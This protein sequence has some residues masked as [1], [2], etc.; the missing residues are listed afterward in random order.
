MK[1]GPV[2]LRK[3]LRITLAFLLAALALPQT[4]FRPQGGQSAAGTALAAEAAGA[5]TGTAVLTSALKS[6]QKGASED[7][8]PAHPQGNLGTFYQ[9]YLSGVPALQ[10]TAAG[11]IGPNLDMLTD[12][13]ST[14]E[15]KLS[16]LLGTIG[17]SPPAYTISD[18]AGGFYGIRVRDY[19][20]KD[21]FNAWSAPLP[22]AAAWSEL[23]PDIPAL[24]PPDKNDMGD[25]DAED[26]LLNLDQ[27]L[28]YSAALITPKSGKGLL[29][30]AFHDVLA[31]LW[32]SKSDTGA[33]FST[34]FSSSVPI[35]AE[36]AMY[37]TGDLRGASAMRPSPSAN[38][39]YF[40]EGYVVRDPWQD[41]DT[42]I[43]LQNRGDSSAHATVTFFGN[44]GVPV[45][46]E[47][48]VPPKSRRT[49]NAFEH[50]YGEVST[51]VESDAPLSAERSLYLQ[52][53]LYGST[54]EHGAEPATERFF[55]EGYVSPDFETYFTLFNPGDDPSEVELSFMGNDG[56]SGDCR[57]TVPPHCRRTVNAGAFVNG[58]FSTR[59]ASSTP[60]V[61]ER[62]VYARG[63]QGDLIGATCS[64]GQSGLTRTRHFAEGYTSSGEFA[65]YFTLGNPGGSD[66]EVT[67]TFLTPEGEERV[68]RVTVPAESRG[69]VNAADYVS[70]E[71]SVLVESDSDVMVERALYATGASAN[72]FMGATVDHGMDSPATEG[73]F[74]E[75]SRRVEIGA[76]TY[77]TLGNPDRD[78]AAEVEVT[79]TAADGHS[80]THRVTVPPRSRRTIDLGRAN[81]DQLVQACYDY[82]ETLFLRE[83][84][85]QLVAAAMYVDVTRVYYDR[86]RGDAALGRDIA[87]QWLQGYLDDMLPPQVEEFLEAVDALA[88]NQIDLFD[89]VHTGGIQAWGV[90]Q[91]CE[92]RAAFIANQLL[93][94]CD[95]FNPAYGDPGWEADRAAQCALT[96]TWITDRG[97]L[98][99]GAKLSL[100]TRYKK[101]SSYGDWNEVISGIDCTGDYVG[102]NG[103][104]AR[105]RTANITQHTTDLTGGRIATMWFDRWYW[106]VRDG[107]AYHT[108][109][110]DTDLLLAKFTV[111]GVD[112]SGVSEVDFKLYVEGTTLDPSGNYTNEDG[113]AAG[114]A[115]AAKDADYAAFSAA[116]PGDPGSQGPLWYASAA[117]LR[118]SGG[119]GAFDP[120]KINHSQWNVGGHA[121]PNASAWTSSSNNDGD[122]NKVG[123]NR[124]LGRTDWWHNIWV[125]DMSGAHAAH[126]YKVSAYIHRDFRIEVPGGASGAVPPPS[127]AVIEYNGQFRGFSSKHANPACW[128]AN[129]WGSGDHKGYKFNEYDGSDIR[130]YDGT[131]AVPGTRTGWF[132]EIPLNDSARVHTTSTVFCYDHTHLDGSGWPSGRKAQFDCDGTFIY[133]QGYGRPDS[134]M[135]DLRGVIGP[136]ALNEICIPGTHDSG[137]EPINPS[138]HVNAETGFD[139]K[140]Y[141]DLIK[142]FVT[143]AEAMAAY[144]LLGVLG[145]VD[146]LVAVVVGIVAGELAWDIGDKSGLLTIQSDWS[147]SQGDKIGEQLN[148]G[149]RYFD[150]RVVKYKDSNGGDYVLSHSMTG[151][152][153]DDVLDDIKR[154]SDRNPS[155]FILLDVNK[156]HM[157]KSQ[158]DYLFDHAAFIEHVENR[159]GAERLIPRDVASLKLDD[160]WNDSAHPKRR[161]VLFYCHHD[162]V[163]SDTRLWYHCARDSFDLGDYSQD[164]GS[165]SASWVINP[166]PD[167]DNPDYLIYVWRN[168]ASSHSADLERLRQKGVFFVM[169]SQMTDQSK[170]EKNGDEPQ[171]RNSSMLLGGLAWLARL[172]HHQ[173]IAGPILW[174]LTEKL[175]GK[176]PDDVPIGLEGLAQ[177]SNPKFFQAVI[178]DTTLQDFVKRE[179]NIVTC[180]FAT[181][182]LLPTGIPGQGQTLFDFASAVNMDRYDPGRSGPAEPATRV[183]AHASVG[184]AAPAKS[185]YLA[186]G[187]T[188][189]GMETF[190]LVQN[191]GESTARVDV[192]FHTASGEVAPDALRGVAVYA[193]QRRTFRVNDFVPDSWEVSTQVT[194][195]EGEVVCERSTYGDGRAWAHGSLGATATAA[196]W[197]LAEGCTEGG[198][199]TW[200]LVQNPNEGAVNVDLSFMTSR[201]RVDGPRGFEIAGNSRHSFNLGE[202]VRDWDVSTVVESTG[203]E[204]ICERAMYGPG[205]AWAHGSLGATA[206]AAEW[207]LAEGCSSWGM[208]TWV[209]VQNPGAE[210][211]AVDIVFDTGG[212]EVSPPELRGVT[213]EAGQRCSFRVNDYVPDEQDISARVRAA[214]GEVVCERAIYGDGGTWAHCSIGTAAPA[215][216]WYLAEGASEGGFETF[217][218][219]QNP[220]DAEAHVTVEYQTGFARLGAGTCAVA[221]KS[222]LTLRVNDTV[223]TYDV[224]TRITSDQP[225][226][227]E[228]ALYYRR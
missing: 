37:A 22:P 60:A 30:Q 54:C 219:I 6:L 150:L 34:S 126:T 185:W 154:F 95:Y 178:S 187:C 131:L 82:L 10:G 189:G 32:S 226:V 3:S 196:A 108:V 93:H 146:F 111:P 81:H 44:D 75:G 184:A 112:L 110:P 165:D 125:D 101:G 25:M 87:K 142:D 138:S 103:A 38:T 121:Y 176:S 141:S 147:R 74:P 65:T 183:S 52:G 194:A 133:F 175:A 172:H 218:L 11:V 195:A 59:A 221:P 190:V 106:T 71:F 151:E 114:D 78:N 7:I 215:T 64:Q 91:A 162:T 92:S 204:I 128:F 157:E 48:E 62:V 158:T 15:S 132:P 193:G 225:V 214:S 129:D 17:A 56:V 105:F 124:D 149:I 36:R 50:T 220:G 55:A 119:P 18:N 63:T 86:V 79:C 39:H 130:H 47:V 209:L 16:S 140:L 203:G 171:Q 152:H 107:K 49:V 170:N 85:Q 23:E 100:S 33:D 28:G 222:R 83:I 113:K 73:N 202:L 213:V 2:R 161:I 180:D 208:E 123:H 137:T 115:C 169:Q 29:E 21:L 156:V 216:S 135:G 20:Q 205:K 26:V 188:A 116:T 127:E 40:A 77:L 84:A 61:V 168:F 223:K 227:A 67:L 58:E 72:R 207:Y 120:T 139:G 173:F 70:G 212:G 31:P 174:A 191:P 134:W 12:L 155:E 13:L 136:H 69:T 148:E 76:T 45:P 164:T 145:P 1:G 14:C 5:E 167:T 88:C 224:S 43:L 109:T 144:A 122:W 94:P 4:G 181:D 19:Y 228:R 80:Y 200:V 90:L 199:E 66:A 104:E 68:C 89:P 210:N 179:L 186:E 27:Y 41:S 97:V 42:F 98:P 35:V 160:L 53:R 99:G 102:A 166:W 117:L 24:V 8:D 159:L 57:I 96:Y 153:L 51:L 206:P 9:Y 46:V 182:P 192:A 217:V 177:E 143:S 197:Y 201:G 198:M 118:R 211:A 163:K